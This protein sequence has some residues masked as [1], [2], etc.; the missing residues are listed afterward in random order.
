MLDSDFAELC[1]SGGR[2]RGVGKVSL[3]PHQAAPGKQR[4]AKADRC[5]F[6]RLGALTGP[7]RAARSAR[8]TGV[9]GCRPPDQA[10]HRIVIG[11]WATTLA[12][13][14]DTHGSQEAETDVR[15]PSVP[16]PA[17]CHGVRRPRCC[18]GHA[19]RYRRVDLGSRA[20]PAKK[21]GRAK[22]PGRQ[23]L[24]VGG[25]GGVLFAFDF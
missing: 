13:R 20:G 19:T 14:G 1:R 9:Q 24:S 11:F 16:R 2:C 10:A 15:S 5:L 18:G 3:K 8:R 6:K 7:V 21:P 25:C 12:T 4:H 23:W 22:R 17:P